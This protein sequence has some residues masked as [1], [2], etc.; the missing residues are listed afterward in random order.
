MPSPISRK[1]LVTGSS[2]FIGYHLCK[3]L[4]ADGWQVVGIDALT[5]YYDVR[6]KTRR[7]GELLQNRGFQTVTERIETPGAL[8]RLFTDHRPD[9]VIHLA[10]QAGV[11]YSIENPESYVNANLVG[12]F[13]VLEAARAVP[14]AHLLL[15]STSS[16]YGASAEMPYAETAKSDT[17]MSF[18]AATKKANEAMAHSYAHLFGL[19]TTMFRFFTVYGPWGRPDMALFKFTKAIL[20]GAPIDIYNHGDMARDFTY[21][22]DL[23][24]GIVRLI[25]VAPVRPGNAE[26]IAEGDSL[27]P[28]APWR[29]VNIGNSEPVQLMDFIAAI[30][31][32]IG[33][34]AIRNMMDMQPGDV[35]ATWAD[36]DLLH[37]LTGYTPQTKVA[38]GVARFVSWYRDFYDV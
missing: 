32:A 27:S 22:D 1:A 7:Q 14:P 34:P 10:A 35:P 26:E 30:E 3:R 15:A 20:E 11:R 36:A 29:V 24:D 17:Q 9:A 18:Y 21:V 4:L 16:V 13:R 8:D 19:P 23:V 33:K 12:T 25:N 5:D 28:V 37:R 38:D 2:G 31:D 6:L